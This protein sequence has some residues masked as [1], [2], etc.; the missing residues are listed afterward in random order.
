MKNLEK[1]IP[2]GGSQKVKVFKKK[3]YL[4]R[5]GDTVI[6]GYYVKSGLLKSYTIDKKGKEHVFMF[7]PEGWLIADLDAQA[8]EQ[9]TQLFIDCIEDSEVIVIERA[10]FLNSNLT[11]EQLKETSHLMSRR[12]AILQRRV[13]MLMSSSAKERY[14]NFL[15]T[16]PELPNR[17]PQRMIASYLGITPEA[18]SKIRSEIAKSK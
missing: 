15:E 6:L 1:S 3:D 18:L 9:P 14:N 12:A 16:Y 2:F 4:Q 11:I 10:E 5:Q 8:F 7:A 17:V 13:I